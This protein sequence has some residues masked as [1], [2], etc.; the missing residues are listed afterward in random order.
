M[1]LEENMAEFHPS[2]VTKIGNENRLPSY[3]SGDR[4]KFVTVRPKSGR[5]SA[6]RAENESTRSNAIR[7]LLEIGLDTL[8]R[9]K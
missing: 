8:K 2:S 6:V 9:R 1:E 7:E 5:A 3:Y 4:N